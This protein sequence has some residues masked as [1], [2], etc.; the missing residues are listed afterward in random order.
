[1]FHWLGSTSISPEEL[2]EVPRDQRLGLP[3]PGHVLSGRSRPAICTPAVSA[4]GGSCTI[5]RCDLRAEPIK[6]S[7]V[8]TRIPDRFGWLRQAVE[9]KGTSV[10]RPVR[11]FGLCHL[12]SQTGRRKGQR[13]RFTPDWTAKIAF[14]GRRYFH[15]WFL[16]MHFEVPV[17][18]SRSCRVSSLVPKRRSGMQ[19]SRCSDSGCNAGRKMGKTRERNG[20]FICLILC[21]YLTQRVKMRKSSSGLCPM[22]SVAPRTEPFLRSPVPR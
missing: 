2:T 10:P 12:A 11:E 15:G 21:H 22:S 16:T 4:T 13:T 20:G 8:S 3:G 9:Y 1:M 7:F 18:S 6:R 19:S 17:R 14:L 5:D